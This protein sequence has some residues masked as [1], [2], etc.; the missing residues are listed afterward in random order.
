MK[1][2]MYKIIIIILIENGFKLK[3][4]AISLVN[5]VYSII[6]IIFS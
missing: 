2:I 3:V 4:F 1:F 5:V 6:I